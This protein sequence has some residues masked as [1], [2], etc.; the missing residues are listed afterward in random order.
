[1]VYMIGSVIIP[2]LTGESAPRFQVEYRAVETALPVGVV[3]LF[4]QI[5]LDILAYLF[6]SRAA[7][8]VSTS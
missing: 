4:I 1:M 7:F 5:L 6:Y 2:T 3:S 8:Q